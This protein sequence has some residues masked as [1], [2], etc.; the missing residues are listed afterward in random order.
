MNRWDRF[1][2]WSATL[3]E[4]KRYWEAQKIL[5]IL[6]PAL[7]QDDV[8]LFQ[9][10]CNC[11]N[12]YPRTSA[13]AI[14]ELAATN[15][16]L[17]WAS[18]ALSQGIFKGVPSQILDEVTKA[19]SLLLYLFRKKPDM[20]GCQF[21]EW[22]RNLQ[23]LQKHDWREGG[24]TSNGSNMSHHYVVVSWICAK[25]T[26]VRDIARGFATTGAEIVSDIAGTV[27]KVVSDMHTTVG[28]ITGD[29]VST[30]R[31][32]AGDLASTATTI[33]VGT[34]AKVLSDSSS[35]ASKVAKDTLSTATKIVLDAGATIRKVRDD[36]AT[37]RKV[38]D[39]TL[40]T[41]FQAAT[42]ALSRRAADVVLRYATNVFAA[43]GD[44]VV[45]DAI[46]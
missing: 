3:N 20:R 8:E 26:L 10:Y 18:E 46:L 4:Q 35:T 30:A 31:K 36:G 7:P 22:Q 39:D 40:T 1:L 33:A 13:T 38:R 27:R 25:S 2:E 28:K 5:T 14:A 15:A 32:I 23:R 16:Y 17:S 21:I 34:L 29:I 43:A 42:W 6:I 19:E 44:T 41:G 45:L 37:I 9:E 24:S 12:H 11:L